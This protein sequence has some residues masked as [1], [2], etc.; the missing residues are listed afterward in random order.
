M[1]LN[2]NFRYSEQIPKVLEF[3]LRKSNV[4]SCLIGTPTVQL[5]C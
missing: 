1:L 4:L 3:A 5:F 2:S